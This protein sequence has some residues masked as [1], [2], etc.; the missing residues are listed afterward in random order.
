MKLLR[1]VLLSVLPGSFACVAVAS[2]DLPDCGETHLV[3]V[4]SIAQLHPDLHAAFVRSLPNAPIA[5][6]GAPF[7]VTDVV[8]PALP[9]RRFAGAV[10][11]ENCAAIALESGGRGYHVAILIFGRFNV[12]WVESS[13]AVAATPPQ[14]IGSLRA[15]LGN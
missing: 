1:T 3:E 14:S 8:D 6:A 12:G 9:N 2:G 15:Y 10:A 7:N 5:D 4:A 11:N 13:R